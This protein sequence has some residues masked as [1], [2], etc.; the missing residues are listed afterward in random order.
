MGKP[1][2]ALTAVEAVKRIADRAITAEAFVRACL[3]RIEAREPDVGAWAHVLD[4]DR[5]AA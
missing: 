2:N 4:A 5:D 1:L 3:E